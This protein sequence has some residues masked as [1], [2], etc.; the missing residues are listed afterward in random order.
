M[1]AFEN[2]TL[3]VY[4]MRTYWTGRMLVLK[5]MVPMTV[6]QKMFW[7]FQREQ[8]KREPMKLEL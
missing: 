6:V 2:W 1:L 4:W 5:Q 7:D 8:R 3:P